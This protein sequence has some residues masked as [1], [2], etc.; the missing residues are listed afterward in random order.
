AAPLHTDPDLVAGLGEMRLVPG[1]VASSVYGS[2]EFM[3][4]IVELEMTKVTQAEADTYKRW[5]DTYQ[6]NWRNYFDP[7]AVRFNAAEGMLGADLS[8][9]PL[10]ANSEYREFIAISHGAKI[11]PGTGDPHPEALA[12]VA[13]AINV[14]SE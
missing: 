11:L 8:V 4:P 3:T 6:Q 7:I 14:K 9:M 1:G 5:R 12:H 10:I 2:L 13:L